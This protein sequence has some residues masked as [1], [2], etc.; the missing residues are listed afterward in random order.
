[1]NVAIIVTSSENL[2]K[3]AEIE[4]INESSRIE[5]KI[6]EKSN[7]SISAKDEQDGL[8]INPKLLSSRVSCD[9]I[10]LRSASRKSIVDMMQEDVGFESRRGSIARLTELAKMAVDQYS[11]DDNEVQDKDET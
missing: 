5:P 4:D 8:D 3:D 6:D 1:L 10:N 11:Y 9:N 7:E 2:V